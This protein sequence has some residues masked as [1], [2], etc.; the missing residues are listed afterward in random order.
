MAVNEKHLEFLQSNISRMN[1]CSFQIKGWVIATITV[2]LTIF[3]STTKENIPGNKTYLLIAI[4][5]TLLFWFIDSMYLSNERRMVSIYNDVAGI[6]HEQEVTKFEIPLK[7]N[8]GWKYTIIG[9]ML[10]LSEIVLYGSIIIGLI[11]FCL[12]FK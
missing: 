7:K 6:T 8:K 5:A 12:I 1:Q 2:L 4:V 11:I 3:A 9:T 10:S